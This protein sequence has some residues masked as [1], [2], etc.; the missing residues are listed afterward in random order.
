M[1]GTAARRSFSQEAIKGTIPN[2]FVS[3]EG[4]LPHARRRV[5]VRGR[6][7]VRGLPVQLAYA[8]IDALLVCVVGVAMIWQR[9]GVTV[10]SDLGNVFSNQTARNTYEGFFLLY[11][12]LVVMGCASQDLYRTPR[13]RSV[14][15]ESLMVA[16]AVGIATMILVVFVFIS[17]SK[18]IS[19][20]VIVS[21]GVL[22]VVILSAWRHCKRRLILHRTA[23][24]IGVSR[25]LIV[26][27]GNMGTALGDWLNSNRQLGYEVCGYLDGEPSTDP[28]ILGTVD[29]LRRI[30][31]SQFA[32]EV[33]IT[34]PSE[35]QLVKKVAF[36]AHQLRLG[37][38]MFPDLYDGLGWSAPLHMIGGFPVMDL[39]WQPIPRMG[40]VIKRLLDIVA[41]GF[42]LCVTAPLLGFL[43]L[44]IR[45]DSPGPA[46]YSADRIGLKGKKF[47][48]YKLRTMVVDADKQKNQLRSANERQGPFFKLEND[49]RITRTG[50]W[51]RKSS[52][53]EL[54]QLWNVFRGDMSLVGPRP[55][56][57]DDYELYSIEH[58]RR[59]DV[60][61]GLTCLWQI[62]A[63]NDPSFEKNMA[64]DLEY[65]ENWS[66]GLD[67][68]ILLRT[69]PA[70]FRAE[71]R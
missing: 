4:T 35:R 70:L 39:H 69:M 49:P 29:E 16:K 54:P 33:F 62:S 40:L 18:E 25:V 41:S 43:A 32:D 22:N 12:M 14:F 63:R 53:D 26:G 24:G 31:L 44:C 10:P 34:L 6:S 30:A 64:L 19:R 50:R 13:D 46:I 23:T 20:F 36:E 58:L 9:F 42:A 11:A 45:L 48:C 5:R 59:L 66:L 38:K 8:S 21:S 56:P 3:K 51:L 65:I 61:P 2:E 27:A 71:G 28:R 15:D 1:N 7:L 47:R 17:G 52:L 57:L 68:R 37:L 67:L 60:T 55:H